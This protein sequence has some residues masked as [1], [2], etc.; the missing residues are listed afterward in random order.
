MYISPGAPA[1]PLTRRF[2]QDP[3]KTA[4]RQKNLYTKK[5]NKTERLVMRPQLKAILV[6]LALSFLVTTGL[7]A[8]ISIF[9]S[10]SVPATPSNNDGQPLEIGMK[11]RSSPGR[12]HYRRQVL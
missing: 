1:R 4:D 9:P 3:R 12:I 10:T 11:F 5:I 6:T 8:Q 2:F 7:Q